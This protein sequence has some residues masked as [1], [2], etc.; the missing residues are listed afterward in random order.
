MHWYCDQNSSS[1]SLSCVLTH[2]IALGGSLVS[3]NLSDQRKSL[4]VPRDDAPS[5]HHAMPWNVWNAQ[6][7]GF[8]VFVDQW[9]LILIHCQL[10]G[11]QK[12][13]KS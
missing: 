10:K 7:L 4:C 5:K 1:H 13:S 6:S 3:K 11:I 12:Q 9:K 8:P 2:Q